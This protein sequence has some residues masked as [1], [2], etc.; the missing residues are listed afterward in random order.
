[1]GNDRGRSGDNLLT[2]FQCDLCHFSNIQVREPN[3]QGEKYTRLMATIRKATLDV[4]VIREPG[5]VRGDLTMAKK[6]R[7]V[8][9]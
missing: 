3:T 5:T 8:A 7:K 4:F 9:K 2:H 6:L 1:M